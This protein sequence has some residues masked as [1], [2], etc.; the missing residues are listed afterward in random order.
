MAELEF[1][2]GMALAIAHALL[3]VAVALYVRRD[4]DHLPLFLF[5]VSFFVADRLRSVISVVLD[6]VATPYVGWDRLVLH[7]DRFFY[8]GASFA[9]A[10]LCGH[11]FAS[12]ATK[13]LA[14]AGFV[15]VYGYL[16]AT[17]P[18]ASGRAQAHIFTNAQ[19]FVLVISWMAALWA[20]LGNA[21]V[22]PTLLHLA[23][24]VLLGADSVAVLVGYVDHSDSGINSIRSVWA[25]IMAA[26]FLS[27]VVCLSLYAARL[28]SPSRA[29]SGSTR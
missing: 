17:Y 8:L 21:N 18:P 19:V 28:F 15:V 11:V 12:R 16:V 20:A 7:L 23:V 22:R 27:Y 1:G 3:C 5:L 2:W 10:W 13:W 26:T 25:S 9:F 6:G 4:R 29:I 24:L 14:L